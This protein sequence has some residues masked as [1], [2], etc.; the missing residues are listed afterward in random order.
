MKRSVFDQL[1]LERARTVG[2]E[3]H[4][5][6]MVT[7]VEKARWGDWKLDIVRDKVTA[8]IVVAADGRNSTEAAG[9]VA[10]KGG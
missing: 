1:L 9:G 3:I 8:P 10:T 2:A 6:A 5:N 4:Q 7:R